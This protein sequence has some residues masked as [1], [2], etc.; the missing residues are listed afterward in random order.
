[1]VSILLEGG[2]DV[3]QRDSYYE[4]TP[5]INAVDMGSI[6]S[7]LCFLKKGL[8]PR[9]GSEKGYR[10]GFSSTAAKCNICLIVRENREARRAASLLGRCFQGRVVGGNAEI[11][12]LLA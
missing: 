3:N 8:L 11:V 5:L 2:P 10:V 9:G 12:R 1:M 6:P 7:H 4:A